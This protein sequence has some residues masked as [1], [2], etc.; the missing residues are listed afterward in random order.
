[1]QGFV[2]VTAGQR[3]TDSSAQ[4]GISA[5]GWQERQTLHTLRHICFLTWS[6]LGGFSLL[7]LSLSLSLSLS[8]LYH[9]ASPGW[10][11]FFR[12]LQ[13]PNCE[14][15]FNWTVAHIINSIN[16]LKDVTELLIDFF[17]NFFFVGLQCVTLSKWI[18]LTKLQIVNLYLLP[19]GVIYSH[20]K[21]VSQR[22]GGVQ[23]D[24]K[25]GAPGLYLLR[26]PQHEVNA[27]CHSQTGSQPLSGQLS[28]PLS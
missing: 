12:F 4:R 3:H 10:V 9:P 1:M 13:L 7:F 17:F 11:F 5:Q 8:L 27:W 6:R 16:K 25:N 20:P 14:K 28:C 22:K 2:L 21:M 24:K 15:R 19:A 23:K 18:E 26:Q